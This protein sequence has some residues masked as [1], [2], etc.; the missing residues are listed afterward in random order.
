MNF[1]SVALLRLIA[2][3]SH[4]EFSYPSTFIH[5][6]MITTVNIF[7]YVSF[8]FQTNYASNVGMLEN[9]QLEDAVDSEAYSRTNNDA[10]ASVSNEISSTA[11]TPAPH[12]T[13]SINGMTKSTY[14]HSNNNNHTRITANRAEQEECTESAHSPMEADQNVEMPST[15]YKSPCCLTF[16]LPSVQ[17]QSLAPTLSITTPLPTAA[18]AAASNGRFHNRN[19]ALMIRKSSEVIRTLSMNNLL[20]IKIA[21]TTKKC[22]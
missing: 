2:T 8:K 18:A 19:T 22:H 15:T 21:T 9:L 11:V 20:D 10:I 6:Y 5:T 14:S 17:M 7:I 1:L 16:P 3:S 4:A 12:I 13:T